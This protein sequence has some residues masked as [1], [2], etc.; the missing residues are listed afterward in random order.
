[1]VRRLR[2]IA[3][4][5]LLAYVTTH[6]L[7]HALGL[8]SLHAAEAGLRVAQWFWR[9]PVVGAVLF[10]SLITHVVLALWSLYQ[11]RTLRM[12]RWD[13]GRILLGLV[14]PLLLIPHVVGTRTQ[15]ALFETD[16]NYTS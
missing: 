7:N 12:A 14:I 16:P 1:M 2:L 5:V 10:G 4:L 8:I 15:D 13:L 9:N 11:R 6:L 3:G